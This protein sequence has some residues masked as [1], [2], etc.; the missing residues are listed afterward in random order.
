VSAGLKVV[1]YLNQFFGGIGGEDKA[2]VGPQISLG[3]TGPGRAIRNALSDQGEVIATIV[4]GDNY[5]V[6]KTEEATEE[7]IRLLSPY[8]PD[9]VIAGPAFEAGRYGIACGTVCKV[10]QDKLGIPAVT[11]MF[12]ENP[13]VGL[14]SKDVYIVQTGDSVRTMADAISKMVS[15]ARRLVSNQ[16]IGE[17]NEEG[18]F[19]RGIVRNERVDKNAA[20]RA[21][22]MVLAK[23]KGEPFEPELELPKFD[24]VKPAVAIKD[25]ASAKVALV[26]D[27]GLVPKGNPENM[28]SGKSTRFAA[29][30]IKGLD[31]LSPKDFEANHTGYDTVFVDQDPNRLVPLDV[32]RDLEKEGIIGSL[33]NKIY[34]TAGVATSL[35]NAQ[36]IGR[37]IAEKLKADKV[38]AVILTST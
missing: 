20:D 10:V 9:V 38:D 1:H 21:V 23:I 12:R 22:D 13:G 29:Y 11:G 16:E 36:R 34:A 3:P 2:H 5:F 18:Y 17:P 28:E 19:P 30:S 8:K 7:V 37:G 24:R 33:N 32:T 31:S 35:D 26:T 14:F 6:E 4:C 27:G 15:I 25:L